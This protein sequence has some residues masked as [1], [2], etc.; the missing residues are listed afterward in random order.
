MRARPG[1]LV[2]NE[3]GLRRSVIVGQNP[4]N[5]DGRSTSPIAGPS[6]QPGQALA[7]AVAPVRQLRCA[8]I[9]S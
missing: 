6:E 1:G 5:V 9:G 2:K 7:Q 4:V 3:D 8:L